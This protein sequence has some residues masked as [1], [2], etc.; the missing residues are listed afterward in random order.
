MIIRKQKNYFCLLTIWL[1]MSYAKVRGRV[2]IKEIYWPEENIDRIDVF[3]IFSQLIKNKTEFTSRHLKIISKVYKNN[4]CNS[5]FNMTRRYLLQKIEKRNNK[6][7]EQTPKNSG[8]SLKTKIQK[9]ETQKSGLNPKNKMLKLML[10]F[11]RIP[12]NAWH[13]RNSR[14][15]PEHS[16]EFWSLFNKVWAFSSLSPFGWIWPKGWVWSRI[17]SITRSSIQRKVPGK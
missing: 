12:S 1:I 2:C 14:W 6:K 5:I 8:K 17:G 16:A 9:K 10:I 13:V 11:W 3:C 15:N 4:N 7:R